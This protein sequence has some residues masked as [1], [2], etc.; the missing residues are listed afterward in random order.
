MSTPPKRL[1]PLL[2]RHGQPMML[3]W[4]INRSEAV[5]DGIIHV[6]G[7]LSAFIAGTTLITLAAEYATPPTFIAVTI[8]VVCLMAGLGFSAAY[9]LWPISATKWILR[10]FDHSAI[11]L[12]IAGTYTPFLIQVKEPLVS[13]GLL[14]GVWLIAWTGV[15]LKL[16][17]PGY[18]DR[19]SIGLYLALGWS[20]LLA[21]KSIVAELPSTALSL[22][23][24][25]GVLYS[26]GVIFHVWERLR[27]QNAVW[28]AFVLLAAACHY[29]AVM[30]LVLALSDA[31]ALNS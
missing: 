23:V 4:S 28:H 6:L 29:A 12:F 17:Y 20:G 2:G 26:V 3:K 11:F 10:R 24:I 14:T 18:L 9:N 30:N 21:M 7:S 19:L 13:V 15:W 31:G 27:F 5:A 8:Y 1:A 16:R 22:L 25:G